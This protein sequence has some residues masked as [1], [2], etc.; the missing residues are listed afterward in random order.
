MKSHPE[1]ERALWQRFTIGAER[2]CVRQPPRATPTPSSGGELPRTRAQGSGRARNGPWLPHKSRKLA[3]AGLADRAR[4]AY[5]LAM[6][7]AF[8]MVALAALACSSTTKGSGGSTDGGAATGGSSGSSSAGASGAG[9]AAGSGGSGGSGG[10]G[11]CDPNDP[12]ADV[13]GKCLQANCCWAWVACLADADC[14]NETTCIVGCL[15]T[16]P[17]LAECGSQ[18]A[19]S[20]TIT[21]PT[22]DLFSCAND[23]TPGCAAECGL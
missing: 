16:G 15:K 9:G 14:P 12:F 11:D 23:A 17:D 19:T 22:N 13:C 10:A 21:P 6:K 4:R 7:T 1:K 3:G 2:R 8:S 18:C 20:G 5:D